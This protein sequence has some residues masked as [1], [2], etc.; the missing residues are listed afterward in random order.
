MSCDSLTCNCDGS[1]ERNGKKGC[2][3]VTSE[4]MRDFSVDADV[5]SGLSAEAD[6]K[7]GLTVTYRLACC[8]SMGTDTYYLNVYPDVVW[9]TGDFHVISNTDWVIE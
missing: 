9:V 2:L 4:V 5:L 1:C 3:S 8:P 6:F 7:S